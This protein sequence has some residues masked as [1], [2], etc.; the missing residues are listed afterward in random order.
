MQCT[1][2]DM[3]HMFHMNKKNWRKKVRLFRRFELFSART[4]FLDPGCRWQGVTEG[5][6][7]KGGTKGGRGVLEILPQMNPIFLGPIKP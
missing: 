2:V 7:K 5:I 1:P 4:F 6:I 3:F